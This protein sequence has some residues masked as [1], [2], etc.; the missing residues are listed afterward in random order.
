[1]ETLESLSDML[2]TTGDIQSIVRTMK[3]LSAVSI[4]QYERAEAAMSAYEQ[5]IDLGL[6][7]M[8]GD[9][10]ARGLALPRTIGSPASGEALVVIGSDR[11]LCGRYNE[12]IARYAETRM[13]DRTAILAVIGARAAARL[14]ASGH[15]VDRLF[16]QP[17][18]V[19]GLRPLVH[20]VI[21]EIERWTRS[22][23]VGDVRVVHN[24]REGRSRAA[25]VERQLLP[26]P[27]SYLEGLVQ[28]G[29]PG[30]GLPFFRADPER[31]LSWLVRQRLFVVLY[32]ALAE[33]LASEHATRL[34][35]MQNAE[36]NIE[37]RREELNAAYRL[38]RQ[39]TITRELLDIVSGFEAVN[40]PDN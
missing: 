14:D 36:R 13:S 7:A 37:E 35:A 11:G 1:M 28:D 30:R 38:K 33:A 15:S 23:G 39:E 27:E 8:L 20:S 21:V 3:S 9:R 12:I 34:A 19:A 25:P 16:L 31:L 40:A 5:T 32:R 17:G 4:R 2:D 18:S 29:W 6:A 24:R 22:R 26:I 10:R